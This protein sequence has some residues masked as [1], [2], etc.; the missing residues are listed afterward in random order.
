MK[1]NIKLLNIILLFTLIFSLNCSNSDP[2][3][4]WGDSRFSAYFNDPGKDK[5]T[6]IDKKI[7]L[8]LIQLMDEAESSIYMAVYN[9]S[10][11]SIIE[12]I[13]RAEDRNIDVKLIG[14]IDEFYTHGYQEMDKH[15][16]DMSLGNSAGIQHN[17]F[18]VIDGKYL[19]MGTGNMTDNGFTRN[20]NNFYII[21]DEKIVKHYT[22]EFMQM[23]NGVYASDKSPR[24]DNNQFIVNGAQLSVY[25]SPYQ[26]EDAMTSLID[27]VDNAKSSVN[28]M[29]FAH[30]HDELDAAMVRATRRNVYVYGIHDSTFV[31]GV[32]E[33]AP[34]LH[35]AGFNNDGSKYKYGPHVRIDGNEHTKIENNPGHGGKMHCKTIIIDAGTDHA[36]LATGSFN[37]S[38]NAINN[39]D[40]NLVVIRDA[41]Y[42]NYIYEQWQLAWDIATDM[43][44]KLKTIYG[45]TASEHDVVM[46][47]IGWAGSMEDGGSFIN[48]SDDFIELYNTTDHDI[49]L[50]HWSIQWGSDEKKNIYPI[51]DKYNWYYDAVNVIKSHE[52]KIV[53][54]Q[55]TSAY[56]GK[57]DGDGDG[58]L[59]NDTGNNLKFSGTKKFGLSTADFKVRLYD[60]AMSLIDEAG[61]GT[62]PPAGMSDSYNKKVYSMER[63]GYKTNPMNGSSRGAWYTTDTLCV[64]SDV[65]P[66]KM[67]SFCFSYDEKTYGTPGYD[68]TSEKAPRAIRAVLDDSTH[69]RMYFDSNMS[70]CDTS[71]DISLNGGASITA[72]ALDSNDPSQIIATVTGITGTGATIITATADNGGT[73]CQDFVPTTISTTDGYNKLYFNK[74]DT[75][76]SGQQAE[77]KLNRIAMKE[78]SDFLELIVT[79]TGSLRGL[80]IYNYNYA[81]KNLLY[82]FS[83]LYVEKDQFITVV[84]KNTASYS[85]TNSSDLRAS[86][87]EN[88]GNYCVYSTDSGF[89]STD[90]SI[91]VEYD[92]NNVQDVLYYSNRDGSAAETMMTGALTYLYKNYQDYPSIADKKYQRPIDE[93]NDYTIQQTGVDASNVSASGKGLVKV[94]GTWE[95]QTSI[96]KKSCP[97]S[98]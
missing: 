18:T 41:K 85:H 37:W 91:I 36:I 15:Q 6:G 35:S 65:D 23:Y 13:L 80:K 89:D 30:T 42:A 87:R 62:T 97:A 78:S 98:L 82:E 28:F 33:E 57:I 77:V 27:L 11:D 55:T 72:L 7:D 96:Y 5:K 58:D 26:G 32:S 86:S 49:D 38:S 76:T 84:L 52:Y 92:L 22:A 53:F 64:A 17:K 46:S 50:S 51:P 44:N 83:E 69:L 47:E 19:F 39:N 10:R 2:G 70:G 68:N 59:D 67:N 1:K 21:E 94:N 54:A 40:E 60:K 8:E 31:T 63:R 88:S 90:D 75:T 34:K 81:A 3:D 93:F 61:D 71:T 43:K 79:K 74:Y 66:T 4:G 45:D 56:A 25:Y 95:Y 9:F 29:I 48:D 24:S 16:I 73:L 12:A 20:N 14:D